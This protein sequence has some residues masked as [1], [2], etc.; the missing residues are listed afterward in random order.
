MTGAPQAMD[1]MM[2][3][4]GK[5]AMSD[6]QRSQL[7]TF[8]LF[9]TAKPPTTPRGPGK[10]KKN[11]TNPN[12]VY[13]N[14][15]EEIVTPSTKRKKRGGL[16]GSPTR[17][18][19]GS[20]P[21]NTQETPSPTMPTASGWYALYHLPLPLA[22]PDWLARLIDTSTPKDAA[23]KLL[24]D[25]VLLLFTSSPQLAQPA[26]SARN[27]QLMLRSKATTQKDA[28]LRYFQYSSQVAQRS[29]F[30]R[31]TGI[32]LEIFFFDLVTYYYRNAT[33]LG[34]RMKD[35]I[36]GWLGLEGAGRQEALEDLSETFR[37]GKKLADMCE[38]VDVFG[39][40]GA[41]VVLSAMLSTD[42]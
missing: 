25:Q 1:R 6:T 33:K 7:K 14:E 5:N 32:F 16:L 42:L 30:D 38:R 39:G 22:P 8:T 21:G 3:L 27:L 24:E 41:L 28:F 9:Y 20:P 19:G 18:P 15:E 10:R 40:P 11:A 29:E 36:A 4:H 34:V 26:T 12:D 31:V 23:H 13:N 37:R 17:L 2:L 35:K